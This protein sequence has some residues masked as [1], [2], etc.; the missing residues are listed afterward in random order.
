M[1]ESTL[2]FI[3]IGFGR[4]RVFNRVLQPLSPPSERTEYGFEW[5]NHRFV[6]HRLCID[7]DAFGQIVG[8]EDANALFIQSSNWQSNAK[9]LL[10]SAP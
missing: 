3:P 8:V 5:S 7:V 2:A 6:D 10:P 9:R 4:F 1:F